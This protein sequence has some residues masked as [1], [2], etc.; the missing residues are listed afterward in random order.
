MKM[1]LKL[2]VKH[3]LSEMRCRYIHQQHA[4]PLLSY[5]NNV[6][7]MRYLTHLRL[8]INLNSSLLTQQVLV[9]FVLFDH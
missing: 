3:T 7:T 5:V 9:S 6:Q 2:H 4:H 8:S 1:C